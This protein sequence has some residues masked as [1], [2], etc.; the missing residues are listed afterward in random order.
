M[1]VEFGAT[2][3][4]FVTKKVKNQCFVIHDH[5]RHEI[6]YKTDLELK[7]SSGAL[8]CLNITSV[9][10]LGCSFVPNKV[11]DPLGP[12]VPASGSYL[13]PSSLI[14]DA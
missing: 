4:C 9:S 12:D 5:S 10:L 7:S 14:L 3:A 13:P 11:R 8:D 6:D 2:R 1:Y